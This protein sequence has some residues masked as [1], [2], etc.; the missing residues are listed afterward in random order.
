MSERC[1]KLQELYNPKVLN[2][3]FA[4]VR[5]VGDCIAAR[6]AGE[7]ALLAISRQGDGARR[8]LIG[9]LKLNII[10]IDQFLHLKNSLNE[11]EI[12]FLC[13]QIIDEFG[14]ALNFADVHMVFKNV[15]SGVYGKF[16]ERLAASDILSWFRE[17]YTARL[18]AAEEYHHLQDEKRYGLKRVRTKQ[19]YA[20]ENPNNFNEEAYQQ[21]KNAYMGE[22]LIKNATKNA[23]Q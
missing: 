21:F 16:Y 14:N 17:Y 23:Q 15:K 20:D 5:T 2:I 12:D 3:V 8:K 6:D 13:E 4:N 10:A 18:D 22:Q 19:N 11:Q 1:E 9:V 7:P